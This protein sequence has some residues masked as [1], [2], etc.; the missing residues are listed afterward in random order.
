MTVMASRRLELL[1]L[2]VLP[3]TLAAFVRPARLRVH[4]APSA[5][6]A[7]PMLVDDGEDDELWDAST[8]AAPRGF[9]FGA[10]PSGFGGGGAALDNVRGW[11]EE[12]EAYTGAMVPAELRVRRDKVLLKWADFVRSAGAGRAASS[13]PMAAMRNVSLA[14]GEE[15]VL[16]GVSWEVCE[17]QI[18]GVVGE[19]GCGKSTQLRLLVGEAL[20]PA[21][22]LSGEVWVAP[23][24]GAVQY[25]PQ[26]VLATLAGEHRTLEEYVAG[27][28]G[29]GA[30]G[31]VADAEA[32]WAWIGRRLEEEEEEEDMVEDMEENMEEEMALGFEE[33]DDDDYDAGEALEDAFG[34][35]A[36]LA[37]AAAAG[38]A[39]FGPGAMGRP[40]SALSSGQQL[41]LAMALALAR[42]PRLLLLDEPTNHLDVDGLE[43]LEAALE[44][45]VG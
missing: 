15:T 1:V 12:T 27:A 3:L 34:S 31:G 24:A 41:R 19:S 8:A 18:V 11:I 20:P 17:G 9:G 28:A 32:A 33:L 37:A 43:W 42:R 39:F 40:V 29:G 25:V 10:P 38:R 6:R 14:F 30:A 45:A 16:R 4:T 44:A 5:I 7:I 22:A 23:E 35:A 2:L 21:A 13:P 36:A 26:E